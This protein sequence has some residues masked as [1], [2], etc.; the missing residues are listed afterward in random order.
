MLKQCVTDTGKNLKI[1]LLIN[2]RDQANPSR[3][4]GGGVKVG[5]G[6]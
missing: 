4:I 2:V 3:E 6:K 5:E 1:Q